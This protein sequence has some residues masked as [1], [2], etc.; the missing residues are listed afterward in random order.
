MD[1]RVAAPT[2]RYLVRQRDR[3]WP[4]VL[5]SVLGAAGVLFLALF[6]VGWPRLHSTTIHYDLIRLRA[7][8]AELE[9]RE[10]AVRLELEVERSPARLAQRAEQLGLVPAPPPVVLEG[11]GP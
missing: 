5:S 7:E 2:N 8:V 4:R 3:Y 11:D 9:R 6:L 10:H 1:R